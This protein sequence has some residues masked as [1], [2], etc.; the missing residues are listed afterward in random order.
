MNY[1]PLR[2]GSLLQI[3]LTRI[4]LKEIEVEPGILCTITGVEVDK[5]LEHARIFVSVIPG[6]HS[7]LMLKRLKKAQ[8][9]FQYLIM[10]KLNIKPLPRI[11]F[12]PDRGAENAARVEK[13]TIESD[14]H[15]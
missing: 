9:K 5:K 8:G 1:R 14:N 10:K 15:K 4:V 6:E 11:E 2:V 12:V 13:L 7:E 3:E